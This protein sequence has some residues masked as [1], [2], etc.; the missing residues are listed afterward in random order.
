MANVILKWASTRKETSYMRINYDKSRKQL[1]DEENAS[2]GRSHYRYRIYE[3]P[4]DFLMETYMADYL[5]NR[6]YHEKRM[7]GWMLKIFYGKQKKELQLTY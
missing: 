7:I 1:F 4:N 5:N 6:Y 2:K 3:V